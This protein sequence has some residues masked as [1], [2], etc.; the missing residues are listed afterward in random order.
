MFVVCIVKQVFKG[1]GV[2]PLITYF[3][4]GLCETCG[5][6]FVKPA[7][8]IIVT[9]QRHQVVSINYSRNTTSIDGKSAKCSSLMVFDRSSIIQIFI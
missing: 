8:L 5:S 1:D 4:T 2:V 3:K 7:E 9:K 6:L